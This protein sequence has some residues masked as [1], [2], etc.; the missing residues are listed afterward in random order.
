MSKE[1]IRWSGCPSRNDGCGSG[2]ARQWRSAVLRN[3]SGPRRYYSTISAKWR[4]SLSAWWNCA[5]KM[6]DTANLV[7]EAT[8]KD[9]SS[10]R[11]RDANR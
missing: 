9:V 6:L 4:S 1:P 11:H 5:R 10:V 8:C 3:H 2:R 7:R